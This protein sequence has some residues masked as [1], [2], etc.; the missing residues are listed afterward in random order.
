MAEHMGRRGR[1]RAVAR[2]FVGSRFA[3]V[4]AGA[5]TCAGQL[6]AASTGFAQTIVASV[7]GDPVTNIDIDERMKMLR[8]LHKPASRDD[9]IESLFADRLE[10]SEAAKFGVRPSDAEASQEVVRVA[11]EMKVQPEALVASLQQAGVS[12]DHFKAH[13]AAD[14]GFGAIVQAMNKGVEA[15]EQQVR[16][17][18]A[19]QGGKAA[20]G[21]EYT[22]RQVIFTVQNNATVA[23]LNARGH[24]AEDLRSR[25]TDCESGVP[26]ARSIAD[27]TVRDPLKRTGAEISEALRQLLDKTPTG[28]LTP[29]Q[30]STSGIEM[31]AVCN[32]TDAK[33]TSA[34]RAAISQRLIAAHIA[35]D[36]KRRLKELRERA[37]VVK[38]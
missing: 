20:A 25:F 34:V 19:K 9:A 33:D 8:V 37:V 7:N 31:I 26:L 29:P 30:R 5:A 27:V 24:E 35:E 38:H 28:H 6:L 36:T 17:E 1:D 11:Q 4:L 14:Y 12:P 22:V 15:S 18:L 32:K 10:R 23:M 2:A 13:F 21:T 3:I 16:A